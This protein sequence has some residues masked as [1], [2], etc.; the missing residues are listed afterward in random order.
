MLIGQLELRRARSHRL[1]LLP[2][3]VAPS[4]TVELWFEWT[5]FHFWTWAVLARLRS[6]ASLKPLDER[7]GTLS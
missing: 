5:G 2:T 1:F 7:P 4:R 3:I 6:K